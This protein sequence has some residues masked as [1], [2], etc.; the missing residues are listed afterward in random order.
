MSVRGFFYFIFW[1]DTQSKLNDNIFFKN[2]NKCK[3]TIKFYFRDTVK[4]ME[5]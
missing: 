2:E 3:N 1:A 4:N 5:I